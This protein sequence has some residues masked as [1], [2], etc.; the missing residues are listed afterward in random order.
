MNLGNAPWRAYRK[1]QLDGLHGLVESSLDTV[2]VNVLGYRILYQRVL[3]ERLPQLSRT[4]MH[5]KGDCQ[6]Y[7]AYTDKVPIKDEGAIPRP[8]SPPATYAPGDRFVCTLNDATVL[9]PVG[10]AMMPDGQVIAETVGTPRLTDRRIGVALAKALVGA[11]PHRTSTS[12]AGRSRPDIQLDTGTVMI[13]PW[14]NYYHWTVECLPRI[15][16]IDMYAEDTGTYPDL[17]VPADRPSWM[18]ET[19]DRID[20]DGRVLGLDANVA[21]INQLVVPSFPDPTP[22]ECR[23]LRERMGATDAAADSK[24]GNRIFVS[25]VDATTRQVANLDIV[26]S[27]FDSYNI[28]TYVLGHLSVAEQIDLFSN[29][30]LVIGAHGAGLT[31]LIYTR[32]ASIIELFGDKKIA[33]FARLATMLGQDYTPIDCEQRGVNLVVDPERLDEAIKRAVE[34]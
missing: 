17:L 34:T 29:A 3:R 32:G 26:Q 12:L 6:I 14:N 25:R 28:K 4:E 22:E 20:Y 5:T 15:R 23:W 21:R 8:G 19:I 30:E 16:L 13:P 11:G 33:S 31:N 10:P 27:V 2:L 24:V 1:Y 9:G 18:D 7:E